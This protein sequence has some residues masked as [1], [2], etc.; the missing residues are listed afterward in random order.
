[1]FFARRPSTQA[2]QRLIVE[3]HELP[4]SYGPIGIAQTAPAGYNIDET[5]V[6]IGRSQTGFDR[7]KAAL[8]S[9]RHFDIGWVE[10]F[11][12]TASVEPGT[13]VA[14]LI[15]HLGFWSLNGCRV[16]YGVGD[17]EGTRCGFAYGTLINHAEAG[18]EIFEVFLQPES[19]NVVYR[20]RA[21]SRPRAA[22]ARLGYPFTRVL[23]AR[24]RRESA[25]A[26]KRATDGPGLRP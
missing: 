23:Q 6:T 3:S 25:E 5:I 15:H 14:V 19:D 13:V 12:P 17:R 21:V 4:L 24:F 7:A 2:I 16:V 18:E 11:P 26:I 9:W 8:A 22:L 1:M 10:L 20:I